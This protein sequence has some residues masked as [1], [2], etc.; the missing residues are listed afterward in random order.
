MFLKEISFRTTFM[1]FILAKFEPIKQKQLM[2]RTISIHGILVHRIGSVN[3]AAD[4]GGLVL[5]KG[6]CSTTKGKSSST[7]TNVIGF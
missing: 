7:Q 4:F 5:I 3:L 2:Y 1:F 6:H